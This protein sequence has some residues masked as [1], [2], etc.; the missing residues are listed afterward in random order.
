MALSHIDFRSFA[1]VEMIEDSDNNQQ[2]I[3]EQVMMTS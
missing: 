2:L 1:S 3:D